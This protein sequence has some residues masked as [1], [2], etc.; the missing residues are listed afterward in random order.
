MNDDPNNGKTKLAV[1][2]ERVDNLQDDITE[3][4]TN[5]LPHLQAK[6]DELSNEFIATRIQIAKWGGAI[7]ILGILLP[8]ILQWMG[9]NGE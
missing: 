9:V 1:L 2:W 7:I 5:H 6:L 8:Y 3:I 4:K